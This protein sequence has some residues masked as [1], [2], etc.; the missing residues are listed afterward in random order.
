MLSID[1]ETL[2]R[3]DPET[4]PLEEIEREALA[5]YG[6]RSRLGFPLEGPNPELFASAARRRIAAMLLRQVAEDGGTTWAAV[7][8]GLMQDDDTDALTELA[9][10]VTADGFEWALPALAR[11][12][13]EARDRRERWDAAVRELSELAGRPIK[14]TTG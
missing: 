12:L 5:A 13:R 1:S 11:R 8:D 4:L 2:D 9:E 3:F 10:V 7:M 14:V 6:W